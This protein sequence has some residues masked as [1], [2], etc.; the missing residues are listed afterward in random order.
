M[1]ILESPLLGFDVTVKK[2]EGGILSFHKVL[3]STLR[4]KEAHERGPI[5][6]FLDLAF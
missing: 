1:E 4:V 3:L 5:P 6:A 2:P